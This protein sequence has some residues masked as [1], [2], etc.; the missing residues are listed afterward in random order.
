MNRPLPPEIAKHLRNWNLIASLH[1]IAHVLL[2]L[3]GILC[4]LAVAAFADELSTLLIRV[5]S[6]CGAASIAI[7]AGFE[8]GNL[9]TRFREAWKLLH[10]ASLEY[11]TGIIEM[12]DLLRA[13]R[14]GEK[15]IGQ[16]HPDPFRKKEGDTE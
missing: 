8:I 4:P 9:A 6:F 1:R 10:S 15:T 7:F 5:I 3:A 16:M 13:Y 14:D 11:E 12:P 2:G